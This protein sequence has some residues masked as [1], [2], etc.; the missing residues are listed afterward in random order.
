MSRLSPLADRVRPTNFDEIAGQSHLFGEKGVL[1]RMV[2]RGVIP[3]MIFFGPPGCGKTTAASIIANQCGKTL[4]KLNA[5]TASLQDIRDVAKDTESMFSTDGVVLYLDEIQYFNK[6]QQQSILEYLEDGRITLIAST[7]E[8]PYY[9]IYDALL[10]RCSVFEFKHVEPEA[11]EKRIM[12]VTSKEF[13]EVVLTQDA[14]TKIANASA[15]DVRRALTMLEVAISSADPGESSKVLIDGEQ[16]GG[17]IPSISQSNFDRDGDVHYDLLSGL[18]KSIRGSDPNAAVFYLAR[19]LEGGDLISPCRRLMVIASEDVGAAYPMA[20]VIV[21]ACID[22]A[23]ELGLPEA[24]IPLGNAA[25]ILATAPKSNTT[26]LAYDA[27]AAD[28]RSGRGSELPVNLRSP[29]FKGY[30]Y[31]H[32]Y[33]NRW[34]DQQY[35]PDDLKDR[36]YYEF[37]DNKTEQA[38]KI[39][40]ENIKGKEL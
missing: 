20:P 14:V 17:L 7:T 13:P 29:L 37:G 34:V 38:A 15:G 11:I 23:R 19:L 21:K 3:S 32:D 28:I 30:K 1:R 33:P 25:V 8:N 31:P 26:H 6:K 9:Y 2:T 10:S 4:H 22:S 16:V 12:Q 24:R 39:Y 5:T 40:W 35:L 18:Q 27:A 36:K